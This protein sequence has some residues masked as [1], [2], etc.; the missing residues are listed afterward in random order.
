MNKKT[1]EEEKDSIT[2]DYILGMGVKELREKYKRSTSFLVK[3]LK[4]KEIYIGTLGKTSKGNFYGEPPRE[5]KD[6][7]VADYLSGMNLVELSK[8]HN[9][10]NRSIKRILVNEQVWVEIREPR[11]ISI[12]EKFRL[13]YRV[14]NNGCWQWLKLCRPNHG[15]IFVLPNYVNK[16]LNKK[17]VSARRYAW[18]LSGKTLSRSQ[19]LTNTCG[20]LRCVNPEHYRIK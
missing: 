4:A 13:S 6:K 19:L 20:N 2:E 12:E 11:G 1:S 9:R 3:V 16:D 7:V 8:V 5:I 10:E 15:P 18:V 17:N 14:Q